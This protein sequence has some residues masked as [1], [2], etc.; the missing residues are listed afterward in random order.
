VAQAKLDVLRSPDSDLIDLQHASCSYESDTKLIRSEISGHEANITTLICTLIRGCIC[1]INAKHTDAQAAEGTLQLTLDELTVDLSTKTRFEGNPVLLLRFASWLRQGPKVQRLVVSGSQL[2]E[3]GV[4]ILRS[5]LEEGW[6]PGLQSIDLLDEME[7]LSTLA[8]QVTSGTLLR[9]TQPVMVKS[10]AAAVTVPTSCNPETGSH[11]RLVPADSSDAPQDNSTSLPANNRATRIIS[12][13][14]NGRVSHKYDEGDGSLSGRDMSAPPS[15]RGMRSA[16]LRTTGMPG[17][18]DAAASSPLERMNPKR[19]SIK[20]TPRCNDVVQTAESSEQTLNNSLAAE[21]ASHQLR[22]AA[23]KVQRN[24]RGTLA[25]PRNIHGAHMVRTREQQAV[26]GRPRGPLAA[27]LP[28]PEHGQ[29]RSTS[30]INVAT[31]EA[32]QVTRAHLLGR[33]RGSPVEDASVVISAMPE[34]PS[35]RTAATQDN[36]LGRPRSGSLVEES[37]VVFSAISASPA[38]ARVVSDNTV[39]TTSLSDEANSSSL[40]A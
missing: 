9:A 8:E 36:L 1:G 15:Q 29:V 28:A 30:Q 22:A 11:P 10:D 21:L 32:E 17:R 5:A 18:A 39:G 24:V 31:D 23:T 35:A 34:S 38:T 13:A 7:S 27:R 12:G 3:Q 14:R 4:Q 25:R 6:L 40:T 37:S 19:K 16:N 20:G 33:A 2:T 26:R